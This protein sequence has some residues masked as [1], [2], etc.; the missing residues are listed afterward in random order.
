M[1]QQCAHRLV[2]L[3][4]RIKRLAV[5]DRGKPP[6]AVVKDVFVHVTGLAPGVSALSEGQ[7]VEFEV[8]EGPKGPQAVM[9]RPA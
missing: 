1:R 9:A 3:R 6:P 2:P 5:A 8:T 7:A 4:Y